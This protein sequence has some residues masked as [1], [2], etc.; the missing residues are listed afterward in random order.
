MLREQQERVSLK[1]GLNHQ[2]FD[3]AINGDGTGDVPN[4]ANANTPL[5]QQP[6]NSTT[7]TLAGNK[8]SNTALYNQVKAAL[9]QQ[10]VTMP[11]SAAFA[12][13]A[14]EAC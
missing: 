4:T 2:G 8:S 10:R 6:N 14:T 13:Y 5:E 9:S 1:P 7:S 12:G 3:I 11:P